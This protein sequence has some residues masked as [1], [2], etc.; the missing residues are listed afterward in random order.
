MGGIFIS[1]LIAVGVLLLTAVPGY[2]FIKKKMVEERCIA[3]FSKLLLY[4]CQSALVIYTFAGTEFSPDRLASLGKFAIATLLIH[5][6]MLLGAFLVLRRKYDTAGAR[7][8]TIAVSFANAGFFGIP[9]IEAIMGDAASG[10][11]VYTTVYSLVMNLL[12]WT[13]GSGIISRSRKYISVKKLF[14]NPYMIST[15]VAIPLFVFSPEVPSQIMNMITI[16]GKATSPLS[17]MIIGMRLATVEVKKLFCDVRVY[18]TAAAKLVVMPLI[19]FALIYFFPI[20]SAAKATFFIV[21]ACPSAS[22][23]LNFSELIGEGQKEAVSSVLMS[24][25]LSIVTLPLLM[26]L[27]SFIL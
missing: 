27:L 7:I 17:M 25:I 18:L 14:V 5:A 2:L 24:T 21:T 19:A 12:G 1:T 16:L 10:L 13:V 26:L 4:V 9:I 11:I 8:S 20:D 3:D 22:I 6:V 15:I 23:V